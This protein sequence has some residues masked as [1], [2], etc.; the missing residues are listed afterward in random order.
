[1]LTMV[2]PTQ[3]SPTR[4]RIQIYVWTSVI[5]V[6]FSILIALFKVKN[7]GALQKLTC[8]AR[9]LIF[10]T[11]VSFLAHVLGDGSD[12]LFIICNKITGVNGSVLFMRK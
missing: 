6:V 7:R 1:M 10:V 3:M 4:Q 8:N 5:F 11:R 9:H 2:T 12:V